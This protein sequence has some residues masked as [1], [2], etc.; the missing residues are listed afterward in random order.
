MGR[1]DCGRDAFSLSPVAECDDK[2]PTRVKSSLVDRQSHVPKPALLILPQS[3]ECHKLYMA[4]WLAIQH[5]WISC[6]NHSPPLQF[7]GPQ[8]WRNLLSSM[9]SSALDTHV[10]GT[11]S[12]EGKMS[13]TK[14]HKSALCEIFEDAVLVTQ[15]SSWAPKEVVDW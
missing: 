2:D 9:R 6:L 7:P 10:P 4:N 12:G 3:P 14:L 13:K 5:V 8:M 15:G 1:I 11:S